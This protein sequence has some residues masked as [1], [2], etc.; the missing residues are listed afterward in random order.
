MFDDIV[1]NRWPKHVWY[2][3]QRGDSHRAVMY[4][5]LDSRED[6]RAISCDKDFVGWADPEWVEWMKNYC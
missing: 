5:I 4:A 1:V 3:M 2:V 6:E